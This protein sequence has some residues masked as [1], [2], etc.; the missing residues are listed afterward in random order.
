[1][2]AF[3]LWYLTL[4]LLNIVTFPL[5]YRLFPALADRGYT[6]ARALGLLFWGFAFWL[7]ASLGIVQNNAGGIL[8]ALAILVGISGWALYRPAADGGSI[9][10][11]KQPSTMIVGIQSLVEWLKTNWKLVLTTE[12]LF[13][14]AFAFMALV[15]A[16]NPEALGTEK[17]MELA[18]INAIIHS[19]TFPPHDPWLSGYSISYYYFGYVMAA[20]LAKVTATSGGVAFNLM[21][22]LMFGL[23]TIG[24]FGIVYNLLEAYKKNHRRRLIGANLLAPGRQFRGFSRNPA[25]A[26]HFLAKIVFRLQFLDMAG[27]SG[28]AR[29]PC[30]SF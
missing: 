7:L 15:R 24:S 18:F 25:P 26:W 21:L 27:Y 4:F 29:C 12:L 13:F 19:P 14:I 17:P 20:L 23:N 28:P 9:V 3:I 11:K 22:A 2:A 16:G 5:A 10:Q 6:L 8:F 30:P 1:M